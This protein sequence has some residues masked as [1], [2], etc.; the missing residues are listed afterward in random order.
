MIDDAPVD[1]ITPS[2]TPVP[3]VASVAAAAFEKLPLKTHLASS[4]ISSGQLPFRSSKLSLFEHLPSSKRNV[5]PASP[6]VSPTTRP[7]P[8]IFA[9]PI[10]AATSS[11]LLTARETVR[12]PSNRQQTTLHKFVKS[13]KI[14]QVSYTVAEK[15]PSNSA[16]DTVMRDESHEVEMDTPTVSSF[17]SSL[18]TCPL[19][20]R[21]FIGAI[22]DSH[23]NPCLDQQQLLADESLAR[24]ISGVRTPP[25]AARDA[26]PGPP[27]ID[28]DDDFDLDSEQQE[29][30]GELRIVQSHQIEG[31]SSSALIQHLRPPAA[32]A[33]AVSG[34]VDPPPSSR[35]PQV[36]H[37]PPSRRVSSSTGQQWTPKKR[38]LSH[39]AHPTRPSPASTA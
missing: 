21:A 15:K 1:L 12:P 24:G 2:P 31:A 5:A 35:Q 17:S 13:T 27:A 6:S 14:V 9:K 3:S 38:K 4:S 39:G 25:A 10:A 28:D 34:F 22:I 11:P 8:T 33:A 16:V 23:V 32:A 30:N 37:S 36:T 19:C 7:V 26:P 29:E 18:S 20:H